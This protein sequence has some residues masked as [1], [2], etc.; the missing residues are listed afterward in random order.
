MSRR[1]LAATVRAVSF[2]DNEADEM[3]L[4]ARARPH[5]RPNCGFATTSASLPAALPAMAPYSPIGCRGQA[6]VARTGATASAGSLLQ[7]I[8]GLSVVLAAG[9]LRMAVAAVWRATGA[10]RRRVKVVGG[11][12]V[13]HR[14]RI[15][16][17]EVAD[18]GS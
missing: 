11:S 13:G 10:G 12:T 18:H 8:F 16:V 7:V 15:M 6:P 17:V 3:N 5:S 14:E 1:I 9:R 4:V 2:S